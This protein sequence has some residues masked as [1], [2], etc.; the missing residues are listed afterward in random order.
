M[1]APA[2][3]GD[4]AT[5]GG[6]RPL[7][8][9]VR[10]PGDKSI[11][12]RALLFAAM[13]EGTSTI[14]GL[15]DGADVRSTATA[16]AGVGVSID[17]RG[18]DDTVVTS[19]GTDA[20]REPDRVLDCGNSGTTMRT[21]SGVLAGRPFLSVLSGDESLRQRPMARVVTPLRAMGATIDGRADG[22]LAPLVIM[23]PRLST[24]SP[25]IGNP[26]TD[27]LTSQARSAA[28]VTWFFK[29]IACIFAAT[30]T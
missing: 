3:P 2:A 7:R 10:V 19:A 18:F 4:V 15:A 6:A 1:T 23:T 29:T 17:A 25:K 12:H 26:A 28:I 11:S 21:L 8:G 5:F 30:A 14:H 22:T 16:L 27:W 13:A 9:T 20:L 24:T